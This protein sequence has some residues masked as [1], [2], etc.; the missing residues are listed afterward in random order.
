MAKNPAVTRADDLLAEI[1]DLLARTDPESFTNPARKQFMQRIE[2][3]RERLDQL[4]RTV[5][6][7]ALPSAFFDPADPSLIGNFVALALIAQD[8]QPLGA[9][10]PFYG[11]GIYAIYY[12]GEAEPYGPISGTE[13]PIYVGKADPPKYCLGTGSGR[14]YHAGGERFST[15]IM[16]L[17]PSTGGRIDQFC[18]L[19]GTGSDGG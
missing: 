18:L 12:N 7:V 10:T 15:R 17:R 14:I 3:M 1:N 8:R 6:T 19:H 11:A 16:E 4:T 13:T 2:T 5:D 9:M